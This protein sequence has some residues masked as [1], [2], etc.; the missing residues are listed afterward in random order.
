MILDPYLID[1]NSRADTHTHTRSTEPTQRACGSRGHFL[2]ITIADVRLELTFCQTNT[3][4]ALAMS[5]CDD[6]TQGATAKSSFS[7]SYEKLIRP[8]LANK[9]PTGGAYKKLQ[10]LK[11]RDAVWGGC[12]VPYLWV[13]GSQ[14]GGTPWC[15]GTYRC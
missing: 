15:L 5:P 7:A 8:V 12:W 9:V 11:Y 3:V 10:P 13:F 6:N 2:R 14:S 4:H 1:K